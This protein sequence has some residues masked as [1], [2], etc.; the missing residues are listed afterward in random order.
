M[1]TKTLLW[2]SSTF[3]PICIFYNL[4]NSSSLSMSRVLCSH[5]NISTC[6]CSGIIMAQ[7]I[8]TSEEF[9]KK[10]YLSLYWKGFVCERELETGRSPLLCP[11]ALC[12][13][14][15]PGLFSR[16]PGDPASLGH[17]LIPASSHQLVY[18]L[19]GGPEGPFCWVVDFS[20]TSC[21]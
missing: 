10:I 17:V 3:Q 15:S 18:K 9:F 1:Y 19:T 13:S 11:S 20:T 21:H 12:L 16:G 4:I 6:A 2:I 7:W 8:K 14:R 5:A